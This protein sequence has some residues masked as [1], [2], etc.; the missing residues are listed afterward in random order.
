MQ[1]DFQVLRLC[2]VAFDFMNF[3][4]TNSCNCA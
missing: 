4:E 3:H 2:L 1:N